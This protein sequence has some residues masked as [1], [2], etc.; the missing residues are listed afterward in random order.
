MSFN[1]LNSSDSQSAAKFLKGQV[2]HVS[3]LPTKN[4]NFGTL[5]DFFNN[6]APDTYKVYEHGFLYYKQGSSEASLQFHTTEENAAVKALKKM[7]E[8]A[9]E[10]DGKIRFRGHEIK[11]RVLEG[12][13]EEK[14]WLDYAENMS[15]NA[16]NMS[17]YEYHREKPLSDFERRYREAIEMKI[18]ENAMKKQKK[19]DQ[20]GKKTDFTAKFFKG[21][22]L[23]VSGLPTEMLHWILK[24]FQRICSCWIR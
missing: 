19:K 17:T 15:D 11:C 13:E 16:Q 4:V 5:K 7:N 2:I 1:S 18:A 23:H 14:F 10:T 24:I 8:D 12:E 22:V 21:Q 9:K 6:Y 3:G 20:S